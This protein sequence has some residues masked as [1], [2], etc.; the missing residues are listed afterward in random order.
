MSYSMG[1][2]VYHSSRFILITSLPITTLTQNR[3]KKKMETFWKKLDRR[4]KKKENKR[5]TKMKEKSSQTWL[6]SEK[7]I[8]TSLNLL[9]QKI[10]FEEDV[11]VMGE[12]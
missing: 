1:T 7:L 5:N 3:K 4:W 2:K 11:M 9:L 6:E 10:I 12:G 8:T